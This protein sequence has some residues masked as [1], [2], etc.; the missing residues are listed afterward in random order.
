MS[1]G[2]VLIVEGWVSPIHCTYFESQGPSAF[3]Q[4]QFGRD[5][6]RTPMVGTALQVL[7]T[8]E[9]HSVS[10]CD[11]PIAFGRAMGDFWGKWWMS[12]LSVQV[13]QA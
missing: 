3:Y 8:D 2:T 5:T 12:I 4:A 11:P 6:L 1:L 10:Q 13:D 9:G 7:D